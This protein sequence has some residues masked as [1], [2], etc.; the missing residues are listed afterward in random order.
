MV[1]SGY[2]GK[3]KMD[4]NINSLATT[5]GKE[6]EGD[7]AQNIEEYKVLRETKNELSITCRSTY[8]LTV[9]VGV[10]NTLL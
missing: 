1:Q 7:K 9:V 2:V 5:R 8:M 10:N 3:R 6:A 4:K